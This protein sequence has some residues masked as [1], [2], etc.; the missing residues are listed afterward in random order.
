[1]P[2][3]WHFL[4]VFIIMYGSELTA[5]IPSWH[6]RISHSYILAFDPL[7]I[8]IAGP[9]ILLNLFLSSRGSEFTPYK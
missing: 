5:S 7:C 3:D 4:I 9:S 8:F 2:H 1:M 6:S